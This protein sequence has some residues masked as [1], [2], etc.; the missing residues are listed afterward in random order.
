MKILF[1][2]ESGDHNLL[3]E[4]I[5]PTFPFFVLTGIMIDKQE[6]KKLKSELIVIKKEIFGTEKIVLHALELTRTRDAKQKE[7]KLVANPQ[8]RN[9]F[10]KHIN[11]LIAKSELKVFAFVLHKPTYAKNMPVTLLDPYFL[12]FGHILKQYISFMDKNEKGEVQVE[13]RNKILDKQFI[14]AWESAKLTGIQG[15]KNDIFKKHNI[16]QPIILKK[17]WDNAGLEL[18]DLICYRLARAY[19]GKSKKPEGNELDLKIINNKNLITQSI[20]DFENI[21][22]LKNGLQF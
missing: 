10:Y 12:A 6:Y 1:I 14:L 21:P 18:A 20:P 17:S 3:P 19:M 13:H 11:K 16:N 9:N 8:V 2:D 4:K 7:L 5:D 22:G 15:M